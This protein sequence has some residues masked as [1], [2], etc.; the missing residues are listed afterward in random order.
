VSGIA[1]LDGLGAGYSSLRPA[2]PTWPLDMAQIDRLA[3]FGGIR[4]PGPRSRAVAPLRR[5]VVPA[6]LR[7]SD[8]EGPEREGGVG[9]RRHGGVV[10]TRSGWQGPPRVDLFGRGSPLR[11][12]NRG[13][14]SPPRFHSSGGDANRPAGNGAVGRDAR[15]GALEAGADPG[16]AFTGGIVDRSRPD[17]GPTIPPQRR[18]PHRPGRSEGEGL[19]SRPR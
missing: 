16:A 7:R 2:P 11:N 19:P 15:F 12:Q 4:S 1:F 17:R 18:Q 14:A 9:T 8:L 13:D 6:R 5:V 10:E 3:R